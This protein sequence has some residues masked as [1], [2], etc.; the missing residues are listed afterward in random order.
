MTELFK[1]PEAAGL[2]D[3]LIKQKAGL[4]TQYANSLIV[5]YSDSEF[6][7]E[8]GFIHISG[9]NP[10]P[11][12]EIVARVI[13]PPHRIGEFRDVLDSIVANHSDPTSLFP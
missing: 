13:V 12:N 6:V 10:E 7:L 5:S 4:E 3:L 11:V 9:L 1:G 8:F 2:S